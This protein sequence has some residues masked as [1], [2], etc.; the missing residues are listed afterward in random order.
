MNGQQMT[1]IALLLYASVAAIILP[2]YYYFV[3]WLSNRGDC[4]A[5]KKTGISKMLVISA[6]MILSVWFL[7]YAVGY[8]TIVTADAHTA[9]LNWAE[10][11]FN[12]MVHALQTFSMDEDYTT[13][14]LDGKQMMAALCGDKP[15]WQDAYGAYASV[16]NFAAPVAGG[17]IVF[18][19]LAGMLPKLW[20]K[21]SYINIFRKKYFFSELNAA[22][23]ALAKDIYRLQKKHWPVLIFTDAY[24][25]DGNEKDHELL[26]EA[27]QYGAICLR[28]DLVHVDKPRFGKREYYLMDENEFGNLQA[29]MELTDQQHVWALANADIYLF[30]QSDAYVQLEKQVI[31]KLE[32]LCQEGHIEKD[33]KPNILPV[34]G[35]R[36]LVHNLLVDVPLY[37]PLVGKEDPEKLQVTVFGNGTIGTEAFLSIY[38]FGQLLVSKGDTVHP[39]ELTVNVVSQDSPEAFWAKMDY[40]NPEIR[41]TVAVLEGAA[42]QMPGDILRY[43]SCGHKNKPYCKVRYVQSDIKIGSFMDGDTQDAQRVLG[44]DYFIIA[45]GSDADNISVAQK[46]RRSIGKL[47]LES[48]ASNAVIAYAVFDPNLCQALNTHKRWQLRKADKT[49]LY[50]YAFGSLEQVYSCDNVY[51][52]KSALWAEETGNA[53]LKTQTK[54]NHLADHRARAKGGENSDYNYWADL[55]RAAHVKYKVFSLGW[56][57]SSVFSYGD[58]VKVDDPLKECPKRVS[59]EQPGRMMPADEYH[60]AYIRQCC[61]NYKAIAIASDPAYLNEKALELKKEIEGKKHCLAWLEHRRWNA[62]TRTM[63][64]QYTPGENILAVKGSQKDMPLKLHA[65]LVE[66]RWPA[67][68]NGQRYIQAE[69]GEDGRVLPE[70]T[71]SDSMKDPD[72]LDVLSLQRRKRSP[73]SDDFKV[74]DYYRYEFE[75]YLCDREVAAKLNKDITKIVKA[76]KAGKF[77]GAQYFPLG[78]IWY[79][80]VKA[81]ASRSK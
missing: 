61:G 81:L 29:L 28:D 41:Q 40:I 62:F 8:Y 27:K 52:S 45:L 32:K 4:K 73:G 70:T 48:R 38:W 78:D 1:T 20:L 56:I 26:L 36:N 25:E 55:A 2:A 39:C 21:L 64:Y 42:C 9:T 46:L 5:C 17:A 53:Y 11:M 31:Q 57:D 74:Y 77:K 49:D 19:I 72:A 15:F 60:R 79:I 66:A 3:R 71:L 14:I 35:Y 13:Y 54:G 6:W 75:D 76:C 50:M 34:H 58:A 69:F 63:G 24:T 51:M 16:L 30:V 18:E 22:S 37:E 47:H 10:E 12:S 23:L 44:S 59:E 33:E 80:P 7:R 67:P 43:D 68:E 65:C